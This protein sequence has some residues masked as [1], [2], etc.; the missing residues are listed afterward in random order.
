MGGPGSGPQGFGAGGFHLKPK[1]KRV[2]T[3]NAITKVNPSEPKRA[4]F[5]CHYCGKDI[6]AVVRIKCAVCADCTLCVECFSVGVEPHP[7]EA[8]HAYH[9]IDDLSFPLF[10][11]DWGADEEILLLEAIEIYGLGNWTEV[12]E[13]VGTKT[14]LQ[15]HQHYFDCYVNSETT[16]LPDMSKV[17]GPKYTKQEPDE[18]PKAKKVKAED[19]EGDDDA[20][21]ERTDTL[22][23]FAR[24][25]DERHWGNMPELTGYNVKRNEFDPEYDIEAELPLAEMEF[26]DTDTELDRKLKIRMLEIYNKRLEERI[27]RKEFIIDRGLLNV[28]RQQALERKRTPQER[29][30][31]GALRVFAR[32]LDPNEYEI[33]LEG[34]MA[35]SRIRNRIAEL[36]E[37]RRNGIHTLSEGEVYDAEKRHRMAEIARIKAIEYPGRGG[38]RANRYLGRD[39]FVQAPVGDAAPKE[40]QKLA[41][42]AAGG[43][44]SGALT[45]LGGTARKKAPLPLDLT[46]LPGVELLNKREKELCV[47]NRLLPV[48]YLSIKEALM[49]ASANGQV[50]K[51][52][53][54]RHMFKVEPIK[55]VRV[56]ELLLQHGWVKDP[57][58]TEG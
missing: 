5:H 55:A 11:M 12:A 28:K 21:G 27:R 15:C 3:E 23:S 7:H 42:I 36:K 22:A 2:A 54:V 8:S 53:E 24:P 52:S 46:H 13:H 16:P 33:M 19:G 57:N 18:E 41:G 35:E 25:G 20:D 14:K 38:S 17:L 30:I 32:F 47:A 37:Y 45:S 44:G 39:G 10:T 34:F 51:R 43:G 49:R 58:E 6:S 9:V 50:L 29:D 40:L 1:R 4:M 26:R 31:H 48:H 56:F